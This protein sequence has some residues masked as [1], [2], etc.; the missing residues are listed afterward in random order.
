MQEALVFEGYVV[1]VETGIWC[2]ECMLPSVV[3]VHIAFAEQKTLRVGI[4][5]T[6]R[7]CTGHDPLPE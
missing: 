6:V 4:R 2:D 7:R 1:D 3:L 5:R